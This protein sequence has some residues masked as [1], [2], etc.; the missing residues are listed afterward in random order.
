MTP[1]V[2]L[3]NP[4]LHLQKFI[5]VTTIMSVLPL[6]DGLEARP[7][8]QTSSADTPSAAAPSAV[9]QQPATLAQTQTETSTVGLAASPA[10]RSGQNTGRSDECPA[11]GAK[12]VSQTPTQADIQK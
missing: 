3:R 2:R 5:L 7:Q 6:S 8:Q 9:E 1:Q 10:T 12:A 11:P 4:V